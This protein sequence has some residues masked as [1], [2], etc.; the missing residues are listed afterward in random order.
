MVLQ[1]RIGIG[2][3]SLLVLFSFLFTQVSKS[4]TGGSP[5]MV[6]DGPQPPPPMPPSPPH[7]R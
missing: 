1:K 7:F 2:L 6:A 4:P 3:L 5:V